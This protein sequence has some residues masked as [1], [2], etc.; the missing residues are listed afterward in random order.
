MRKKEDCPEHI[1]EKKKCHT[2]YVTLS[3]MRA[4]Y[5]VE[6]ERAERTFRRFRKPFGNFLYKFVLLTSV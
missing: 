3:F 5:S 4:F 1:R 2:T 6:S